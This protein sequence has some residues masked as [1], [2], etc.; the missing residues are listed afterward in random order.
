MNCYTDD[1]FWTEN[2][3]W[4][5]EI[6]QNHVCGGIISVISSPK[7]DK[8]LGFLPE[9]TTG[10]LVYQTNRSGNVVSS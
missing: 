5:F 4:H 10:S 3:I 1:A 2:N 8:M 6:A 7:K 9:G